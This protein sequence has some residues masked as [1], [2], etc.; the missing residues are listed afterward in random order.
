MH[1]HDGGG[2]LRVEEILATPLGDGEHVIEEVRD[3]SELLGL[4]DGI[5]SIC[6]A[7]KKVRDEA[8]EWHPIEGYIHD[9]TGAD[10]SHGLCPACAT[11][12]YPAS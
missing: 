4:V 1:K 12:L 10:F 9:R 8:G 11:Q 3:I 7:C 5:L 2:Q 6:A